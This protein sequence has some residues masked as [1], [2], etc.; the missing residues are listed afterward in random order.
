MIVHNESQKII[1]SGSP[2]SQTT[3]NLKATTFFIHKSGVKGKGEYLGP[4]GSG[5][6]YS[7]TNLNSIGDGYEERSSSSNYRSTLQKK[8]LVFCEFYGYN[9][10]IREQCFKLIGYPTDWT[11]SK[12]KKKGISMYIKQVMLHHLL[13]IQLTLFVM[14]LAVL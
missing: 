7:T 4:E 10:H 5:D 3:D 12:K 8:S 11:K 1:S 2:I 13:I 9:G 6:K 14:K